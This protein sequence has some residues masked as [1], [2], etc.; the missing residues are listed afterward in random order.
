[1][2]VIPILVVA[3]SLAAAEWQKKPCNVVS[4]CLSVL[5]LSQYVADATVL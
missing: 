4:F 3:N 1:V 2:T 5:Y